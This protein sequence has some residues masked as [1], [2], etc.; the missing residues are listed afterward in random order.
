[1]LL[2]SEKCCHLFIL[3]DKDAKEG[4]HCQKLEFHSIHHFH[5]IL[6]WQF[7]LKEVVLNGL[8]CVVILHFGPH[9]FIYYVLVLELA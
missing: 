6:H 7:Q 3:E 5:F 2:L 4:G 8:L 9:T 1:M